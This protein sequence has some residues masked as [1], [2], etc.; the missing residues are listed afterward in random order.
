MNELAVRRILTPDQLF[1]F[2]DLR[3][4]FEQAARENF[5]NRRPL[6]G[7]RMVNRQ[8]KRNDTKNPQDGQRLVRPL[9]PPNQPRPNL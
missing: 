5:Q 6:N 3:Q 8:L 2:R 9:I 7:D 4:R 1:R